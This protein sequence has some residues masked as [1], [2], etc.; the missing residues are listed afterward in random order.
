MKD[1]KGHGSNKKNTGTAGMRLVGTHTDGEHHAKVYH[2]KE[3][4]EHVV[5]Y[6]PKGQYAAKADSF[7]GDK[8][9][10]MGTARAGLRHYSD[11]EAA[12][13]LSSGTTKSAPAPVHDAHEDRHN[14][15]IRL[16]ARFGFDRKTKIGSGI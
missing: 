15:D 1:R 13:K 14:E 10:A 9:D 7:H 11:K 3:W 5:K 4:G 12:S 16:G 6:F 2:N 8:E